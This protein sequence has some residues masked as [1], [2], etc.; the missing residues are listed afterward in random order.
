MIEE[1]GLRD[2]LDH[3]KIIVGGVGELSC[4]FFDILFSIGIE[5]QQARR[6][7][8]ERKEDM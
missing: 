1:E 4:T 5:N 3:M 8:S 6:L 7:R 2:R